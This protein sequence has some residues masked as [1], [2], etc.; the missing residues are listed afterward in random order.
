MCPIDYLRS[1]SLLFLPLA[2]VAVP[3]SNR[4]GEA[5]EPEQA[6]ETDSEWIDLSGDEHKDL[7]EELERTDIFLKKKSKAAWR[8]LEAVSMSRGPSPSQQR[9]IMK[10]IKIT[11][12]KKDLRRQSAGFLA[13]KPVIY[14]TDDARVLLTIAFFLR[15][16]LRLGA[17]LSTHQG[18][19]PSTVGTIV[20][21]TPKDKLTIFIT[22]YGFGLG[23]D[24]PD[25]HTTFYSWGLAHFLDELCVQQAGTHIPARLMKE[26]SGEWRMDQEREELQRMKEQ[27]KRELSFP[28]TSS[29]NCTS[30]PYTRRSHR[31]RVSSGSG[32]HRGLS[33]GQVYWSV[34]FWRDVCAGVSGG[35]IAENHPSPLSWTGARRRSLASWQ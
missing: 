24:L 9:P 8:L 29:G 35:F 14:E 17:P 31:G 19:C 3:A 7:R 11:L 1:C 32:S 15:N 10:H 23:D 25:I 2:L 33:S 12:L 16:P 26:L 5:C 27:L 28:K 18:G 20:V 30:Q 4:T 21:V 34:D 13:D 6:A 22:T